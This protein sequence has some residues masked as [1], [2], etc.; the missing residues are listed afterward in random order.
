MISPYNGLQFWGIFV[1][2]SSEIKLRISTVPGTPFY[3]SCGC[4]ISKQKHRHN[5]G[6]IG[7]TLEEP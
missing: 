7:E 1:D 4:L 3:T 2:V 6:R 5:R